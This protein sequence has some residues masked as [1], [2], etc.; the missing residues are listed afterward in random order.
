MSYIAHK[1]AHK[2]FCTQNFCVQT[3]KVKTLYRSALVVVVEI[4]FPYYS[5]ILFN[6]F[7]I[8][9]FLGL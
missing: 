3:I 7:S 8:F 9:I 6:F 5:K 1:T 2:K 4:V